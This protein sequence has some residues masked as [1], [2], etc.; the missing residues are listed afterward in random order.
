MIS[1]QKFNQQRILLI[2]WDVLELV[3]LDNEMRE[4]FRENRIL[5]N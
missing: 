2:F 5:R 1:E 4:E 3:K